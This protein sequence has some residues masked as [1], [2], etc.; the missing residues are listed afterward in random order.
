MNELLHAWKQ[1]DRNKI[2]AAMS[3]VPGLGHLYKHH[4]LQGLGLLVL[5]NVLILFIAGLLSLGTLGLSLI[6]V[7]ALWFTGVA[8]AAYMA[9]DE[10]G[11]HPWLHVWE[12]HWGDL[13]RRLRRR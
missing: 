4:Y 1:V 3:V 5:G 2:A 8:Y 13:F 12:Y 10:H 7:P 6:V 9:S 11:H